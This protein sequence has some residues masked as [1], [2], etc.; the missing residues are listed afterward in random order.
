MT[1]NEINA[2]IAEACPQL[3]VEPYWYCEKCG[4]EVMPCRVSYNEIHE[5]CGC[6]VVGRGGVPNFCS[7]LNAMHEAEVRL[8][9]EMATCHQ[10]WKE[11]AE[12]TMADDEEEATVTR[13]RRIGNANA[14]QR[15]E[16]FLRTIGKWTEAQKEDKA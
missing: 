3:V 11:L 13:Y 15:A 16:A 2:A 7:D 9:N 8:E 6:V 10:Y 5:D 1:D 12:I 14:R 4:E